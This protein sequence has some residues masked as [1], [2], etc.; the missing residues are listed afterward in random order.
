MAGSHGEDVHR[1]SVTTWQPATITA[2]TVGHRGRNSC[3]PS[4]TRVQLWESGHEY[5]EGNSPAKAQL[6]VSLLS[7]A[8]SLEVGEGVPFLALGGIAG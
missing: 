6:G 3:L 1:G 2:T 8:A 5:R 4:L 7:G